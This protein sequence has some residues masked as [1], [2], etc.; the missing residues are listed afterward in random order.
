MPWCGRSSRRARDESELT[1]SFLVFMGIAA[2]ITA[3]G[4]MLDSAILVIG[5][6]VVGPDYGPIAALCV[7]VVRGGGRARGRGSHDGFG[8]AVAAGAALVVTV[9]LRLLSVAPDEYATDRVLTSFS[10]APTRS[11][12][13]SLSSPASSGCSR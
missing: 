1:A 12:S 13:S 4:I 7:G 5:G 8:V 11:P 3:I 6:M 10:P 2:A 9:L